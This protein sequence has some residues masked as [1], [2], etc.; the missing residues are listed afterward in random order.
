MEQIKYN[1]ATLKIKILKHETDQNGE[2]SSPR[3]KKGYC[4]NDDD[5]D[6]EKILK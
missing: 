3:P 6:F 2:E 5:V 1:I 4:T